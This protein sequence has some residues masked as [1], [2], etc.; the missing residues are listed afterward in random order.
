[1]D[2]TDDTSSWFL[3]PFRFDLVCIG[4][5][6]GWLFK[7]KFGEFFW[8][9]LS[10]NHFMRNNTVYFKTIDNPI[11]TIQL[12]FFKQRLILL[13]KPKTKAKYGAKL[14]REQKKNQTERNMLYKTGQK[15]R[16]SR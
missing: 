6:Y 14:Q 10:P 5:K 2:K 13:Q 12:H 16:I 4:R 9:V 1:M 7:R 8:V 15:T 11:A 3:L